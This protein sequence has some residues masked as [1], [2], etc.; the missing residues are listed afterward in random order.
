MKEKRPILIWRIHDMPAEVEE[1]LMED[2]FHGDKGSYRKWLLSKSGDEFVVLIP[3]EYIYHDNGIA[4]DLGVVTIEK[5][6][7]GE[8]KYI[9]DLFTELT[10]KEEKKNWQGY[11]AFVIPGLKR[12]KIARRRA[13]KGSEAGAR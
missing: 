6:E 3:N 11:H 9:D 4:E 8:P 2:G 13:K 5:T 7:S 12:P 1:T 10:Y